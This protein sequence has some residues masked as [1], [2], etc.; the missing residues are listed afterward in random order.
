[1]THPYGCDRSEYCALPT[2][3]CTFNVGSSSNSTASDQLC[4][5]NPILQK[6]A[7]PLNFDTIG[8]Q[9][10]KIR[11]CCYTIFWPLTLTLPGASL[12]HHLQSGVGSEH[13]IIASKIAIDDAFYL[14]RDEYHKNRTEQRSLNCTRWFSNGS[15]GEGWFLRFHFSMACES[16]WTIY[17]PILAAKASG[18][19]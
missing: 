5:P 11:Q 14:V 18:M 19:L 9:W 12:G 1:M 16:Q 6:Y 10:H 4:T 15:P 17:W 3:M 7:L 13:G 8:L 2:R